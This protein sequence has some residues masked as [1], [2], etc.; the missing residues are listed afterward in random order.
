MSVRKIILADDHVLIRRGLIKII[1]GD[2][3][4]KVIGDVNDGL[5]LLILLKKT[6]PDLI[7]LDISMPNLRGVEAIKEVK[8]LCPK[9]KIL[10]LTMHS[11]R[12][13]L[14]DTL[15]NGADGYVLK[16]DSDVELLAAINKCLSGQIYISPVL[17]DGLSKEEIANLSSGKQGI[18]EEGLT[19]RE[20]QVLIL[21]AEGKKSKDVADLLS[22]SIRTVE[23]HRANI[24]KKTQIKNTA[25]LIKYAIQKGYILAQ[26]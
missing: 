2:P 20:K 7:L 17:I 8:K 3:T 12:D 25:A 6:C 18:V 15:R 5:E 21:V 26:E 1:D 11:S 14:S 24:M 16:E 23:H 4:L 10:I 13:F 22:I 19:T 9:A